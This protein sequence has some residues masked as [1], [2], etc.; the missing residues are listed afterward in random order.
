MS[1]E[2][3]TLLGAWL[4][5]AAGI[6]VGYAGVRAPWI[7]GALLLVQ[8]A[9]VLRRAAG[10]SRAGAH[11]GFPALLALAALLLGWSWLVGVAAGLAAASGSLAGLARPLLEATLAGVLIVLHARRRVRPTP[12]AQLAV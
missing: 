5:P 7:A 4:V 3:R 1:P 12:T 2:I 8:S 6:A 9:L 10:D 11:R